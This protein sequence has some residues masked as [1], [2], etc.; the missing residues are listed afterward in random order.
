[1]KL[2]GKLISLTL[3]LYLLLFILSGC[4]SGTNSNVTTQGKFTKKLDL[5]V[6]ITQGNEYTKPVKVKENYLRR[7]KRLQRLLLIRL[8][9]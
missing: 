8:C 5:T 1:M 9:L 3:V 6:W 4:S 2:F 7:L